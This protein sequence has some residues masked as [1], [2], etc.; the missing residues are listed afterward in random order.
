MR[1]WLRT[2][3]STTTETVSPSATH[4]EEGAW[5]ADQKSQGQIEFEKQLASQRKCFQENDN[6]G[7]EGRTSKQDNNLP[8]IDLFLNPSRYAEKEKLLDITQRDKAHND[9]K[10]VGKEFIT[11]VLQDIC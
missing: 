5:E 6:F 1:R 7:N 4:T 9:Q 3:R 10:K 11:K 2:T 8:L